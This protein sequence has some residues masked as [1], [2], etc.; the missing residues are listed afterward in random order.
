MVDLFTIEGYFGN[1]V[2]KI[3]YINLSDIKLYVNIPAWIE[4]RNVYNFNK[5][6]IG[7]LR[8]KKFGGLTY[9][10]YDI[11]IEDTD[12]YGVIETRDFGKCLVMI[13]LA[14]TL[15]NKPTYETGCY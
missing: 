5:K 13:T 6:K 3:G 8:P 9:Y 4:E 12:C 14:T 2:A 7:M 15:T 1:D 11:I 10:L